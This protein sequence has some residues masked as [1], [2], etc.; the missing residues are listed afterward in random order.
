[1]TSDAVVVRMFTLTMSA[2]PLI[3]SAASDS[4]IERESPKTI[5]HTP[6]T[7]TTTSSVGRRGSAAVAG[8]A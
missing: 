2:A 4:T 5:M 7:A 6:K 1:M 8:R 3:A